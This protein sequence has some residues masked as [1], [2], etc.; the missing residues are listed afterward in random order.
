MI[1]GLILLAGL[2]LGFYNNTSSYSRL[3]HFDKY[4][5]LT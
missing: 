2:T 3:S 1:N 5:V 4:R